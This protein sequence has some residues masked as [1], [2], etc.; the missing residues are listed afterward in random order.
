MIGLTLQDVLSEERSEAL[1][2]QYNKV[3][4]SGKEHE[5]TETI[6]VDGLIFAGETSLNPIMTED[7]SCQYILAVVRDI[8]DRVQK[9]QELAEAKKKL[10]HQQKRIQSLIEQNKD[11]VF[12]LDLSG[13]LISANER[14][15]ALTGF[16]NQELQ[17]KSISSFFAPDIAASVNALL[18][19]V[20]SELK[21]IEIEEG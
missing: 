7:G 9:E 19:K 18:K 8:T 3:R 17:G 10:E 4:V 12:E 2:R 16:T 11:A 15:S 21:N 14:M 13:N 6:D 1:I 20:G 5:F